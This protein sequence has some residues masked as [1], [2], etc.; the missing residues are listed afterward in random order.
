MLPHVVIGTVS[1]PSYPLML[2]VALGIG[3]YLLRVEL[4]RTQLAVSQCMIAAAAGCL[5]GP[6]AARL[7]SSFFD[8]YSV[9]AGVGFWQALQRG[10]LSVFGGVIGGLVAGAIVC[11][12]RGVPLTPLIDAAAPGIA[13]AIGVGRIG[14]LMSGCCYGRPTTFPIA[15]IFTHWD[16]GARPLGVP[17]HATQVYELILCVL[18]GAG[19]MRVR[20]TPV[21]L[22]AS[23]LACFY[24]AIRFGLEFLRADERGEISDWPTT[25]LAALCLLLAG[26]V[27]LVRLKRRRAVEPVAVGDVEVR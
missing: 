19:L 18:L 6:A 13:V 26:L 21:G 23:L 3:T 11:R 1:V 12:A 10:G 16:A 27:A 15:L 9:D 7:W 2:V 8:V 22:R 20:L 25:Q 14:C 5:A 4:E 17:L 24:G